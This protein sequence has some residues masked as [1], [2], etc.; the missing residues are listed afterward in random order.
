MITENED[1]KSINEEY[2]RK[3]KIRNIFTPD[4]TA[5]KKCIDDYRAEISCSKCGIIML[6]PDYNGKVYE[7]SICGKLYCENCWDKT[8]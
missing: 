1:D 6:K 3:E 4:V 5:C 7:R 2:N 8:E